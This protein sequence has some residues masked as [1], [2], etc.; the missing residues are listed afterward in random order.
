MRPISERLTVNIDMAM[1]F[2]D[3]VAE[4][5]RI[6]EERQAGLPTPWTE[7]PILK[8][9]KFTN[10]YRVLDPGSQFIFELAQPDDDPRDVLTRLFLYRYTNRPAAWRAYAKHLGCGYPGLAD[11]GE[12]QEFWNSYR[13]KSGYNVF[14]SAY[15]IPPQQGYRDK[16]HSV[17]ALT[18]RV[19]RTSFNDFMAASSQLERL[20]VL[21]G[22]NGVGDFMAMQILTD[23]GY[24]AQ[25]GE[26]R[27]HEFVIAG[28]GSKRGS[29]HIRPEN[30]PLD[31][32]SWA[33]RLVLQEPAC[34]Q[35]MVTPGVI[36]P[37][38]LMDIQNCLCEFS[39]YVRFMGRPATPS[40][41]YRPAH[42][43]TQP[44]PTL[45]AH[46]H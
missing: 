35:L 12:L 17:I 11:L 24:T 15:V 4:R 34:P 14:G 2:L 37:P 25:C 32:I 6:W 8:A 38:S 43:G 46:W 23:W 9:N 5:H 31:T 18:E 21:R 26:D 28:P 29:A 7:D 40:K 44:A 1:T 39:K 22:H 3:F 36:R 16:M 42:P 20:D 45:P 33:R 10:V 19:I 27:E 41:T 13:I 30:K